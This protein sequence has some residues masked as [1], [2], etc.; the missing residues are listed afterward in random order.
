MRVVA[1]FDI[2]LLSKLTV[3]SHIRLTECHVWSITTGSSMYAIN[4]LCVNE[5]WQW[6]FAKMQ[7]IFIH[8]ELC[9]EGQDWLHKSQFSEFTF[10]RKCCT[11]P[12]DMVRTFT[13]YSPRN[14]LIIDREA[15][16]IMYLVASVCPS[17]RL[18]TLYN[19]LAYADNCADAVDLLLILEGEM[20][21]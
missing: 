7:Y 18:R 15:R 19:Q 17:V 8:V 14:E 11:Y 21:V 6:G 3:A 5:I 4:K 13:Y 12:A 16:E 20:G 2:P 9:R 1:Y 10:R